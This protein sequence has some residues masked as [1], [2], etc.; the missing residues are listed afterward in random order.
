M[1][2]KWIILAAVLLIG[3]SLDYGTKRWA[4]AELDFG[5]RQEALG[6]LLKL[7]LSYN[8]GAAFGMNLGSASRP[9][10][11]LF[12][13]VTLVWL[14]TL[15]HRTGHSQ[16]TRA[17]GI[18]LVCAGAVGNLIDRIT[19]ADGVVDFLGP[20]D[21]GFM[22][23]PIFNVADIYVV[24]GIGLLLLSLRSGGLHARIDDSPHAVGDTSHLH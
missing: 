5:V 14:L 23:W 9:A 22:I 4:Q 11:I 3:V 13:L 1:S 12:T 2:R 17:F 21:L 16:R 18:T 15:Y 24:V 7:T 19:S 8:R 10:F 20:Y 6:G